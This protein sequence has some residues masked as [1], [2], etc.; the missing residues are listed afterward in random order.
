MP[1]EKQAKRIHI[2]GR[3]QG[4]GYRY[5]AQGVAEQIGLAGYVRNLPDGGVEVYAV[6][7]LAQLRAL[8]GELRRG[9][10]QAVV[11]DVSET[12]ANVIPACAS[13]FSIKYDD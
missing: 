13:G 3:V 5:F 12:D 8:L 9:P 4:V 6:G 7:T 2:A 10:R 11:Q 1:D